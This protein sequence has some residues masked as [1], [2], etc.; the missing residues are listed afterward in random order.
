[1]STTP[2]LPEMIVMLTVSQLRQ[3]IAD[4]MAVALQSTGSSTAGDVVLSVKP[5]PARPGLS[6]AE[7]L[8]INPDTAYNLVASGAFGPRVASGRIYILRSVVHEWVRQNGSRGDLAMMPLEK[9][10]ALRKRLDTIKAKKK[11]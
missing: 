5:D 8:G 11:G 6:I 2:A 9:R 3:V 4:A 1:M 10:A 7:E